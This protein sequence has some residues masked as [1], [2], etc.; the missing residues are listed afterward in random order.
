MDAQAQSQSK[1][2][3]KISFHQ[4]GAKEK[5]MKNKYQTKLYEGTLKKS[6]QVD[7]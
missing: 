3:T 6:F 4:Q 2:P 5:T 1:G 7:K